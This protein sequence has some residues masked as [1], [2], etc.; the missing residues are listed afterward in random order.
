MA[1]DKRKVILYVLG[2]SALTFVL[3]GMNRVLTNKNPRD[4]LNVNLPNSNYILNY[5]RYKAKD[6]IND[7]V[8]FEYFYK[9][10]SSAKKVDNLSKSS[11]IIFD[12]Y[13]VDVDGISNRPFFELKITDL[14]NP[15]NII[16]RSVRV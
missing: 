7:G 11:F 14:Q 12:K 4:V 6:S 3:M 1:I 2:F 5:K 10:Q 16:N 9:N 13:K 15:K 8:V